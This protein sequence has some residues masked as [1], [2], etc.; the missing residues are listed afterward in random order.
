MCNELD[1]GDGGHGYPVGRA[2]H[3]A[4]KLRNGQA[5]GAGGAGAGRHDAERAGPCLAQ[6]AGGRVHQALRGRVGVNGRHQALAHAELAVDDIKRRRQA[7]G[8]AGGVAD[9]VVGGRVEL[10]VVDAQNHG[11][12]GIARGR[13]DQHPTRA[14]VQVRGGACAL[15]AHPGRL[16]HQV[17]AQVAPGQILPVA[18]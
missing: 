8:G 16:H 5:D 4:V 10:I 18:D 9:D 13:G 7:V 17:R 1:D 14:G 11:E 12:V 15:G 3:A 6:V 2:V